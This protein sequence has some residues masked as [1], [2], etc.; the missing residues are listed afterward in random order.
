MASTPTLSSDSLAKETVYQFTVNDLYGT[1]VSLD[2]Y[3]GKV[4]LIVNTASECG[5]TPQLK[6][7]ETLYKDYKDRGLVVLGFPSN[8]FG[9]QEPLNGEAIGEFCSKNYGVSFPLFEKVVVKGNDACPLYKFLGDSDRNGKVSSK[10]MWN[11]HKYLIDREG[12]VI[13][14]FASTTGP[15]SDK[16]RKAIETLL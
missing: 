11:F 5:L 3:K 16:V 1:Q 14:Y 8:D 10:P 15:D 2:Q 13:D 7:L 4:L 6:G 12:N 9:G